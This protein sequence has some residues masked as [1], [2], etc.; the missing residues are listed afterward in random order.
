M[1]AKPLH[2]T[3]P[4]LQS[5]SLDEL[6]RAMAAERAAAGIAPPGGSGGG[7]G[8]GGPG[9]GLRPVGD[10]FGPP[11]AYANPTNLLPPRE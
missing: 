7:I 1:G 9:P 8:G 4:R 2:R 11:A 5:L 6:I 10:P 3:V